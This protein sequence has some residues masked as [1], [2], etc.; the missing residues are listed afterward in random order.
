MLDL[1]EVTE[2]VQV[3]AQAPLLESAS[4]TLGEVVNIRTT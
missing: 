4:S 3:E 2:S 1:G